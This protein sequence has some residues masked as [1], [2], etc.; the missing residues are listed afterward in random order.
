MMRLSRA[1]FGLALFGMTLF[2]S[3][4]FAP[5]QTQEQAPRPA[6]SHADEMLAHNSTI[7]TFAIEHSGEHYGQRVVYYRA[8]NMIPPDSRR[9]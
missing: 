5:A 1:L 7:W 6:G 2:A 4:V 9:K 3:S 8:N